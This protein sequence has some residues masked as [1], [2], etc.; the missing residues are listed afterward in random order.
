MSDLAVEGVDS[1][2]E[3]RVPIQSHTSLK[4]IEE[5]LPVATRQPHSFSIN[6]HLL[7]MVECHPL[8]YDS[9]YLRHRLA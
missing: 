2:C 6:V 9:D 7:F 1:V 3:V 4:S 5:G 8:L